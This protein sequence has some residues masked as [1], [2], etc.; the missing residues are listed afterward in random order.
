MNVLVDELASQSTRQES[1]I[2]ARADLVARAQAASLELWRLTSAQ[3]QLSGRCADEREVVEYRPTKKAEY[4]AAQGTLFQ[5]LL[6][7]IHALNVS[8]SADSLFSQTA[9]EI[10]LSR[11]IHHYYLSNNIAMLKHSMT[12]LASMFRLSTSMSSQTVDVVRG[13]FYFI[14]LALTKL[15]NADAAPIQHQA[16]SQTADILDLGNFSSSDGSATASTA[17]AQD[18]S[19]PFFLL[20]RILEAQ[21]LQWASGLLHPTFDDILLRGWLAA[22]FDVRYL[23][24]MTEIEMI[25]AVSQIPWYH[26]SNISP[27]APQI[28]LNDSNNLAA[29]QKFP[30]S[31]LP[32]SPQFAESIKQ[33]VLI[34]LQQAIAVAAAKNYVAAIVFFSKVLALAS[35]TLP[36]TLTAT[37]VGIC[38][39]GPW[40][41]KMVCVP[42]LQLFDWS[43]LDLSTL[44]LLFGMSL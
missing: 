33:N 39:R 31:I 5:E 9:N 6:Q 8:S 17:S 32:S 1:D 27:G 16:S 18:P 22:A 21:S 11:L 14:G 20:T 28:N 7:K 12:R 35:R 19:L 36:S 43:A 4:N 34:P 23:T 42:A 2:R 13:L 30:P 25:K 40:P 10:A 15:Q 41:A 26:L 24:S 37:C 3:L 29:S 44:S 38:M